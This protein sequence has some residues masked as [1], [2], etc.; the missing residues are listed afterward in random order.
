MRDRFFE[1]RSIGKLGLC[2]NYDHSDE[3]VARS[4][5]S[6]KMKTG[7]VYRMIYFS[8]MMFSGGKSIDMNQNT[9]F[10]LASICPEAVLESVRMKRVF[11]TYEVLGYSL[12]RSPVN[13]ASVEETR[14]LTDWDSWRLRALSD[15]WG[16]QVINLLNQPG[17]VFPSTPLMISPFFQTAHIGLSILATRIEVI[18]ESGCGQILSL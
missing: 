11:A 17:L 5:K 12:T 9:W 1:G 7:W 6:K 2:V 16:G 4:L 15:M 3:G 14:L 10:F 13:E 18:A 8:C